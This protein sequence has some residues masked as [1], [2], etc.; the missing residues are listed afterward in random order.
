[1]TQ[2]TTRTFTLNTGDKIPAVGLGTWQSKPNEVKHAVEAALRRGYRHIDTALAYNNE[3]EVG[4]GI[5]AS[6]VPREEIWIT[7][8]LDNPWHKRV[9][10]GLASSLES[11]QTDYIDLYLI[12]WPSST[13]PNDLKKHYPD[14]DYVDT[15]R[16]MQK[17]VGTGKVR[18]IGVSNFGITHLERLLNDPSC[19]I[20]PAVN[21]IELH[22]C[23]PSPKL[24]EYN[25]SKGIHTTAYSCLGSTD[26]PLYK[27]EALLSMAKAKGK[28]PQQVL[29][30]WG[31]QR[32]TSVIP[33]SVTKERIDANFDLDGWELTDDEMKQLSSFTERF[34][35]CDGTFLP[36]GVKVFLGDDE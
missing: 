31:L 19:K 35:V 23:N 32:G 33:K 27:N 34:K 36:D 29:L 12:H 15:W 25:T 26:S 18:N 8:K 3:R 5:K 14:W 28:T 9:P 17:L 1:M 24:L 11:L 2:Q 21:Q 7:T 22:P 4:D 10:E 6:G 13:D 16:E 20:V 30:H